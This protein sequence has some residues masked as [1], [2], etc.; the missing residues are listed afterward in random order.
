MFEILYTVSKEA[1]KLPKKKRQE[2]L[3][4]IVKLTSEYDFF[5]DCID[6]TGVNI[7]FK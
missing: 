7:I 2:V 6:D 5:W 4:E 3:Q 1:K